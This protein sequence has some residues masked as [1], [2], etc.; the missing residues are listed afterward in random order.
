[1][2]RIIFYLFITFIVVGCPDICPAIHSQSIARINQEKN[3]LIQAETIRNRA[4][5]LSDKFDPAINLTAE[6]KAWLENHPKITIGI[7]DDWLPVSYVD[8]QGQPRGIG[9]E[10]IDRINRLTGNRLIIEPAPF[11]KNYERVKNR[12]IDAIMDISHHPTREPFFIFTKP[13]IITSHVFVGRK[14]SHYIHSAMN[15]NGKVIALEKEFY[16]VLYF[17][18][19]FPDIKF[20]EYETTAGAL[21]SVARGETD[22]YVGNRAVVMNLIKKELLINL[23]VMALSK[24]T[25]SILRIGVRKDWPQLARI[26]DKALATITPQ[27]KLLIQQKHLDEVETDVSDFWLTPEERNWFREH[28]AIP[29]G[30]MNNWPPF[31]YLDEN[32]QPKGIGFDYIQLLNKRLGGRLI[33]KAAPFKKN[34]DLVMNRELAALMDIT[35]KPNRDPFFNFTRPYISIPH[36]IVGRKDSQYFESEKDLA[37]KVVALEEGFFNTIHFQKHSPEIKIREYGSTVKAINAVSHGKADAYVGNRVVVTYL[38]EKEKISNLQLMGKSKLVNSKLQIGIR[39]DWPELV[40]IL[41]RALASINSEEKNKILHKWTG[42]EKPAPIELELTKQEKAWRSKHQVIKVS[43]EME[44]SP[45]DFVADNQP[46]G[47]AI[48]LINLLA[49]R[50]GIHVNFINGFTWNELEELFKKGELDILQPIKKTAEHEKIAIFSQPIIQYKTY[51]VTRSKNPL[52]HDFSQLYGKKVAVA[53]GL[54]MENFLKQNHP[55]IHILEV[56]NQEKMIEAVY[57]EK[58]YAT[59]GNEIVASYI[60]RKKRMHD[61]RLTGWAKDYDDGKINQLHLMGQKKAPELISMMN[62]ALASMTPGE[63]KQLEDKWFD[64]P[65]HS[66]ML[67]TKE[68]E[69]WLKRHPVLRLGIDPNWAPIEYFNINGELSGITADSIR[70]LREKMGISSIEAVKGLSWMEV[71]ELAQK[72]EIDIVSAI[73][74]NEKRAEYLLFTEPYLKL[75]IVVV[76]HESTPFI[77][78]IHDLADTTIALVKGY[79]TQTYLQRDYPEQKHLEF[80]TLAEAMK[81]VA[82]GRAGAVIEN[83]ASINHLKNELKLTQLRVAAT[84]QYSYNISVGVRKDWPELIPI[85]EKCLNSITDRE[86]EIIRDKWVNIRFKT[87]TDWQMVLGVI[88]AV[89]LVAGTIVTVI[90]IWNRRLAIEVIQRKKAMEEAQVERIRAEKALDKVKLLSGILPICAACKKIRDDKGYWNQVESY[91]KQHSEAE[92]S[93]GMCPD[94]SDKLYGNQDWY[95]KMKKK[96]GIK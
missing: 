39:R 59:F 17:K 42:E 47:Y 1:M 95:I 3:K 40:A 44:W 85:I 43:N 23:Q 29:I 46:Q 50:I 6:E 25:N 19:H 80:E 61:L 57:H 79:V 70:I 8:E 27:E 31:N 64:L 18:E 26:L 5:S 21:D 16:N 49:E 33:I 94:C 67:F 86:K 24:H 58:A 74:K 22:A 88:L 52:V 37:G 10:F 90:S 35:Q 84:T 54:R 82:S 76:M 13:Y 77:E 36:V 91:I 11:R 72:G 38:I 89:A 87:K 81:A 96:K 83:L 41:D 56:D 73:V 20:K 7:M 62:K 53:K 12:E 14:D 78:G 4:N 2:L 92:F 65:E 48:D 28:P 15:L 63:V 45:V 75:P 68:E 9:V 34:F 30:T 60:I 51:F 71:L 66:Q 69:E 55:E 32:G 93:H